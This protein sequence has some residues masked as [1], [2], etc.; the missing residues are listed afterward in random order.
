MD[1]QRLIELNIEIEGALRVYAERANEDALA[2]AQ[3]KAQQ[4]NELLCKVEV[5]HAEEPQPT[6]QPEAVAPQVEPEEEP[7]PTVIEPAIATPTPKPAAESPTI[8]ET[9]PL[10]RLPIR[11]H[12]T[13]N[14]MYYFRRE[15][16]DGYAQDFEDTLDLFE[17][18]HSFAE[19]EEYMYDDLMF[20]RENNDVKSFMSIVENYFK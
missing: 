2:I 15:V 11:N 18:M 8:C 6:V 17:S 19:A 16:F 14:D 1:L 13:I 9:R 4:L 3:A 20:D 5:E 12:F 7:M 10:R